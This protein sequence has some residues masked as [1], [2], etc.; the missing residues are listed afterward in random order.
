[1]VDTAEGGVVDDA[2]SAGD[3]GCEAGEAVDG[4]AGF[5]ARGGDPVDIENDAAMTVFGAR[6]DEHKLGSP[7]G[8]AIPFEVQRSVRS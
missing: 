4:G 2:L 7:S 3:V 1:V 8:V 6:G 5:A